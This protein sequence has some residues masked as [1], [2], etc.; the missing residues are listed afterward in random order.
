V[1]LATAAARVL[2]AVFGSVPT[3][4]PVFAHLEGEYGHRRAA[5]AVPARLGRGR[6]ESIVEVPLDTVDRTAFDN[7]AERAFAAAP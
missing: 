3:V 5:L 7:L 4:L 1:A 6:L 2:A